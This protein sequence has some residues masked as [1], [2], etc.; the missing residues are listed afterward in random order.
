MNHLQNTIKSSI[1]SIRTVNQNLGPRSLR[2]LSTQA[3][4]ASTDVV[5][6]KL[7]GITTNTL[8]TDV[9][10]LLEESDLT[11][12]DLKVDYNQLFVPTGMLVQFPSRSAYDA[13]I[14]A[15]AR[16]GR[17]Y[18]LE[19]ADRSKWNYVQ[20]YGGKFVLLQGVPT[21]AYIEDIERFLSGCEY[22]PASIRVLSRLGTKMAVVSF[23]SPTAAMTAMITKNRGFCVSNQISMH[24]LQ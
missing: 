1:R 16:K 11:A 12:D 2:P 15:V 8:K 4:P 6:G 3:S 24:V 13:A 19:M 5:Y 18:K 7:F 9:L 20:P 21:N 22:D 17:L 23:Q 14:R 10:S